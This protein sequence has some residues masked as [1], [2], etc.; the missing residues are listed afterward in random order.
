MRV[1]DG[2]VMLAG[3]KQINAIKRAVDGLFTFLTAALGTDVAAYA[4]TRSLRFAGFA[5]TASKALSHG[6]M[7]S[8]LP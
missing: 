4:W 7:V 3:F 2:C 5:E 6:S 8:R 1:E